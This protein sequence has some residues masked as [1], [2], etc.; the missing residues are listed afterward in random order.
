MVIIVFRDGTDWSKANWVFRQ[1]IDDIA[2]TFPDDVEL[3]RTME[4]ARGLGGLFLDS[5]EQALASGIMRAI[6]TVAERTVDGRI[7]GWRR[8]RPDDKEGQR[9]YLEA[10]S[11]ILDIIRRQ[12]GAETSGAILDSERTRT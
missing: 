7:Q 9:M 12:S 11:E 8:A 3:R 4:R 6:R 1:L 5:M 10:M 2:E